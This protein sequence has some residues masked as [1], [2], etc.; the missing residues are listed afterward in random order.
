MGKVKLLFLS[1][2]IFFFLNFSVSF[3]LSNSA[4][5]K[6]DLAGAKESEATP[7]VIISETPEIKKS[8]EYNLPYPGLLPDSPLYSLKSLRD[9]IV[10][11]LISS[12]L[13][14]A[15]FNLLQADK[16]LNA[17][18]YLFNAAKG[19]A[20]K[21]NLAIVTISKAENYFFEAIAEIRKA[22][23][24][25]IDTKSLTEKLVDSSRK[26]Q[27]VVKSLEE[28]SKGSIRENLAT[29]RKRAEGFEKD[30][31]ALLSDKAK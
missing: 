3:V 10:S 6:S 27:E 15:E 21:I 1:L 14:K 20:K 16:R 30:V 23:S 25:G 18:M 22:N 4:D 11:F 7:L 31:I 29:E 24:Q 19:D 2:L 8:V 13:K 9:K 12:P 5:A 17:G 26:H 28:K